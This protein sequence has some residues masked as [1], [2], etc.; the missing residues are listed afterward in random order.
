MSFSDERSEIRSLISDVYRS[1]RCNGC[2]WKRIK[3]KTN[4]CFRVREA[5]GNENGQRHRY[6]RREPSLYDL[7]IVSAN[8]IVDSIYSFRMQ[9]LRIL[10]KTRKA[11][12]DR[13]FM[14]F[15]L[16]KLQT[17]FFFQH[18]DVSVIHNSNAD[19][20]FHLAK[21]LIFCVISYLVR[22]GV[23][24]SFNARGLMK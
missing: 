14:V 12:F 13:V 20:W 19:S 8:C 6:M 17:E 3:Q 11:G 5:E 15:N 18:W 1:T 23:N 21:S 24:V 16:P 7:C 9:R 2:Y 10:E 4:H 22:L